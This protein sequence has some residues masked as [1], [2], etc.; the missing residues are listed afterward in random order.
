V[1]RLWLWLSL[2]SLLAGVLLAVLGHASSVAPRVQAAAATTPA[3]PGPHQPPLYTA[4][5]GAHVTTQPGAPL[6]EVA[7]TFDDGPTPYSSPAIISELEQTHT[8]ATF[9]V[10]GQYVHLWPYLVQ[11]EWRDGFAI[12]IHTWDHPDMTTLSQARQDQQFGETIDALHQALGEDACFWFWRPPYGNY[13]GTV[14]Q[15]ARSFGL[16]T[17]VWNDDPADWSRPG[18]DVIASRVLAQVGP[19]SIILMHDGP[20]LRDETAAA[21]PIILAG[22][23]ARGLR[24]VTIPQLLAD[25]QYPGIHLRHEVLAPGTPEPVVTPGPPRSCDA[26]PPGGAGGIQPSSTPLH[27]IPLPR[28]P[29]L[30]AA[31]APGCVTL[32]APSS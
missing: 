26:A 17:I 5:Y 15:T 23:R 2:A 7:L 16:T 14:L 3:C 28:L 11:R 13:N 25:E 30:D 9:F 12:G 29:A 32:P 24:P 1:R 20:A 21:L 10:L 27:G 22:L 18:T 31:L 8:P 19:A 4:I 6:D